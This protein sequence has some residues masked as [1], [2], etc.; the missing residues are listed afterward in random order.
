MQ[1]NHS[2]KV[3]NENLL[4][5]KLNNELNQLAI[6]YQLIIDMSIHNDEGIATFGLKKDNNI[7]RYSTNLKKLYDTLS[8][9]KKQI[10]EN[11]YILEFKNIIGYFTNENEKHGENT[12]KKVYDYTDRFKEILN[13]AETLDINNKIINNNL[14]SSINNNLIKSVYKEPENGFTTPLKKI[15]LAIPYSGME[16]SS[17]EQSNEITSFIL[18]EYNDKNV[19]SPITHSHPLTKY[20]LRTTWNFW[21]KI[22]FQYIDWA[23]EVWVVIPKE[24]KDKIDNSVGVNAEIKYAKENGK[25]ISYC[26]LV[27]VNINNNDGVIKQMVLTTFNEVDDDSLYLIDKLDKKI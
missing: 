12:T 7:F 6:K 27:T 16:E 2:E 22:D 20:G 25:P 14:I 10:V 21:E 5:Y 13:K 3:L 8:R 26:E 23:D 1:N 4:L 11:D 19:F 17:Y 18:N 9:E 15:Y 24:G